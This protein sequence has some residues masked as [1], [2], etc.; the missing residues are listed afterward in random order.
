MRKITLEE[1]GWPCF[2]LGTREGPIQDVVN[3]VEMKG[4]S[5]KDGEERWGWG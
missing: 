1:K 5:A 3:F 4:Y 2:I